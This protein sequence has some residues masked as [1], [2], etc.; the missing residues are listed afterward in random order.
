M[1]KI[2]D[3]K[4]VEVYGIEI[5]VPWCACFISVDA[6]GEMYWHDMDG[7]EQ[8]ADG[9]ISNNDGGYLLS[10]KLEGENWQDL[11]VNVAG[12]SK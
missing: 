12:D 8:Y 5:Q 11:L 3:L 6:N 9:W 2:S 1:K 7:C 4:K 10:V